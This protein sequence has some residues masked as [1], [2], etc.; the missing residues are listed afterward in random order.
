MK[1]LIA[2]TIAL[3]SLLALCACGSGTP[4]EK[5]DPAAP[6]F[7]K[8]GYKGMLDTALTLVSDFNEESFAKVI[9][10]CEIDYN[11][12]EFASRDKDYIELVKQEYAAT[13]AAYA[14]TYGDDWKLSYVI[15]SV[16]EK[17]AEGIEKYKSFDNF[18]FTT[19]GVDLDKISAV[20]FVKA[21]V[22]IEGSKG[23]NTKDKTLQ[24]FCYNNEWYSFYAVRFGFKL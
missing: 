7:D 10:Q 5:P 23:S 13:A 22:K 11:I 17:D 18:Y 12:K 2:I 24:C 19:Y 20:T 4:A 1:K 6:A 15:N 14:E 16:D 9:P 3:A 21:T 8:E